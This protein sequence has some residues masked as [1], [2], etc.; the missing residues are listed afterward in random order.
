[1]IKDTLAIHRL[2]RLLQVAAMLFLAT[3]LSYAQT[4]SQFD[5]GTPP[6]HAAGVSSV[7]SYISTDLG[8]VNL[9][10]GALNIKLP[11]GGVG[12]RGFSLPISLNY[13][14]KV[15]SLSGATDFA[16]ET[17]QLTVVGAV[18][19]QALY[20]MDFYCRLTPGWTYGA[21]PFLRAQGVHIQPYPGGVGCDFHYA[22]VK[23]TLV[24]PDRGE[25]ELRDDAFDGEP[26]PAQ[27]LGSGCVATDANRG[28]R[29]H[30]TDGSGTI[31]VSDSGSNGV[32]YGDLS[33][34]IITA[35]GMRYHF[36]NRDYPGGIQNTQ[37]IHFLARCDMI[38][39]R[40]GNFV[41]ISYSNG[42]KTIQF[43]DQLGRVTIVKKNA[44]DPDNPG[45]PTL[46]LLVTLP[47][48][49][50]QPRYYKVRT[51]TMN[52]HYRSDQNPGSGVAVIVGDRSPGFFDYT[53][54]GPHISLFPSSEGLFDVEIDTQ[55][56]VTQ[57]VLPDG[58]TLNFEYNQYGEVARIQLPTGASIECDY[59]TAAQLPSGDTLLQEYRA[60]MNSVIGTD[61]AVVARRT[62]QTGSTTPEA[63]WSYAFAPLTPS[64]STTPAP[65]TEVTCTSGGQSL[66]HERHFFL[67]AGRYVN[68][69]SGMF[70]VDGTHYS[71]WSTSLEF[72][73][74]TFDVN[75]TTVLAATETDWT[76]RAGVVW[77]GGYGQEQPANDNRTTEARRFL[78]DGSMARVHTSYDDAGPYP[79]AN[80]PRAVDEYDFDGAIKRHSETTYSGSYVSNSTHLL[81][82]PLQTSTYDMLNG[83]LFA[84][85]TFE[86][87]NYAS[88][89]NH[90]ALQSYSPD[91]YNHNSGYGFGYTTRGNPT[92]ITQ[93]INGSSFIYTYP[94]Y[95]A[96]GNV[97]ST[98]DPRTNVTTI[99][100]TDDFGNGGNPGLGSSGSFGPTYALPTLITSPPP[101]PGEPQQMARSQYDFNTGL[102]TGFKDRNGV[103]TQSLYNDPF[104]RPTQIKAA[105]GISGLENHTAMY[106]A[107]T[108]AF[109][110]TLTNNDVLT[111]KD[112]VGMDDGNL[113]SWARTDGF[114]RTIESWTEDPQGDVRVGTTYDGLG[115]AKRVTNP[116]RSTSD[117]TYGYADTTYDMLGRVTRIETFDASGASTGAVTTAYSGNQVT[118]TDQAGKARRSV[119]DGLGR[120]KQVIEDPNV[121]PYSTTYGYDA[122]DD[123]TSVTQ[124][125]QSRTFL[126]DGLK[127]LTQAIN[128]ESGTINYTYDPNSNLLTKQD[129]RLITTTYVYD[130]LNR[131]TSRMYTNDPQSTPAV[132]YKYD[133]QSLPAN[134]PPGFTR[135]SSIGRLVV[136]TYG[137]ASA[138]NYQGYDQLGRVN[139]SYQQSDSQNYG[140]SYGYNLAS[141]MTSETYPSGKVVQTEY[142]AAGRVAGVKSGAL[143][144]AG[145]TATD[146]A[147]RIQYAAHGAVSIMKLGN[148]KWE[149]ANFNS[150]LQPLQIGVGTS[151]TN[152]SILQ[153][154]YG[155][156]A[157]SANNGNVQTQT[158]T[159]GVTVM[160]QSFGYDALNRLSSASEGPAW[161]QT[162]DCDRYGNRAVRV[163]SYIPQSQLTPQSTSP[164]D[165][166]AF[167]QSTNKIVRSGFGYDAAGNLTSD[168]TTAANA[169]I[170][171]AENRQISYTKASVTTT[172]SYDGDGRRV[173]KLDSTGT[174]IIFVY[175]AGGQLI[176]EYHSDPVPPPAGGG[177]TSYL[178]SDHL[179]STRVV[180]D[181][182]GN[183]KARHDYLPFGEELGA[184]IGQRT[185]A[186]K[187]DAP[188]STKQKFTQK[189]RD[190]ES[191]L[192]YF[193]ARYYSSAQGR[194]TSADEFT[195]G[196]DDLFDFAEHA[197][198]NPTFYADIVDPQTLNKYQYAL[199]NPLRYIDPDGHQEKQS[200][201][202]RLKEGASQTILGATSAFLQDN[203]INVDSAG[204]S[205]GRFIGHG[206]ALVQG[207]VEVVQGS[208]LAAAGGTEAVLTAPATGTGVGALIP[209]A[210]VAV[211]TVGVIEVVH[212]G[213]VIANTI[214]NASKPDPVEGS[215]GGPGAGKRPSEKTKDA[216]RARDNNQCVFCG[217]ETTRSPGPKQS[218]IDHA[219]PKSRGGNINDKNLQNTCRACNQQ[220]R[221]K[222]NFE[223]LNLFRHEN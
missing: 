29:W 57:L 222:N 70:G 132:A 67:P 53:W 41:Q 95:D 207:V 59:A 128:P 213:A 66:L 101:N 170:Y 79:R 218:N 69:N 163:G 181:G 203:G 68:G 221:A 37:Q 146:A 168:P 124:G 18:Y 65:A 210:G 199:N 22:L 208:N 204:N 43:T 21:V 150:R 143:Y 47:G 16:D 186:L 189:E 28:T 185:V 202:Q 108:T 90:A 85:T 157:A 201:T 153:L 144:Y 20:D 198:T 89:G 39:D 107:P 11:L 118:V 46:P 126:Y 55:T 172:Y 6:Q 30:A 32:S 149:H 49:Q 125:V 165:F 217:D 24:M 120:L 61:R 58:R 166:T 60:Q 112:Q 26:R 192:D 31:F 154:D 38:T 82:L 161:S 13:S 122:L 184:G 164:T 121:S 105:L 136:T 209:A 83:T 93:M 211:A 190:S 123:L 98:K 159:I 155:Y 173:K 9:A 84:Q 216:I 151:Q 115:R 81:R 119:T 2:L 71:L 147:N 73:A 102:L 78:D 195:G 80:N 10:N 45:G 114:G 100:Y 1:M 176:A 178:T 62:Y 182:Q 106:Y 91:A 200:L 145:A 103:I 86:Y 77:S 74:E 206:A 138:G 92:Q 193:L 183:V 188:D 141:A 44:A 160:T 36:V 50:G 171:D 96:L 127:R 4:V 174:I 87:D 129:A 220:K 156:G 54:Q 8:T 137:G 99:S 214:H 3:A 187:Y 191:G 76:Q 12:G 63:S 162:Y 194:F 135:G 158:I 131:V 51:D 205:V 35:D 75:G 25:I 152:S 175:N 139:V 15:W 215:S 5:R 17:H 219:D 167:N 104:D 64:N 130:A 27:P 140:F 223:F 7:G 148:G 42:L 197:S 110:V 212:G 94:R 179:G 109:G 133:N 19:G 52:L 72:R 111:A 23:L 117:Q 48:Y 14:S 113:R 142:D 180:T 134:F 196:P 116:Y 97:V 56:V 169:M 34:T 177:G 40:N 88:D 33:G